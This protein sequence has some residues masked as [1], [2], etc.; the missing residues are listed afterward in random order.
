MSPRKPISSSPGT[1]SLDGC[2]APRT[3]AALLPVPPSASAPR[4]TMIRSGMR[5]RRVRSMVFVCR[6]SGPQSDCSTH[7]RR[8]ARGFPPLFEGFAV[9]FI[10]V[11]LATAS[12]AGAAVRDDS[13]WLQ[14]K[15]DAGGSVFLPRL[16]DGQCYATRGLW[17]SRDD[18]SITSDGACIVALGPG[19]GRIRRG[20]GTPV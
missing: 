6:G 12:S 16:P 5:L 19:P 7:P 17:V 2:L 8:A 14:A 9:A 13:D 10:A 3:E 4:A 20:G 15:L 18:T 1:V 11:L